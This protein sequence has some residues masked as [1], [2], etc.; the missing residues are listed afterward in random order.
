MLKRLKNIWRLSKLPDEVTPEQLKAVLAEPGDG[1][2]EF[3]SD[4]TEQELIDYQHEELHGW[5]KLKDILK[6]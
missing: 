1:Q 6:L 4:M 5:K 3:L 2:A